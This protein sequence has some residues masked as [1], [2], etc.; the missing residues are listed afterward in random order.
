MAKTVILNDSNGEEV[1]PET[2]ISLVN[3][4]LDGAKIVNASV[5]SDKLTP[6]AVWNE[7]IKDGAVTSS[8]IRFLVDGNSLVKRMEATEPIFRYT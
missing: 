6:N 8:K 5:G 7:N 4:E 1:Y 3:G 2:D